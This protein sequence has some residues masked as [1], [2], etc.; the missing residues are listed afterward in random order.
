MGWDGKQRKYAMAAVLLL[1]AMAAIYFY[2]HRNVGG[3]NLPPAAPLVRVEKMVMRDMKKRVVLS[4]ETVARAS[5]DISPK[6]AGRIASVEVEL[7]DVV[8]AGE[9]LIRQDVRDVSVSILQNHAQRAEASAEA[10]AARATFGADTAKARTNFETAKATYERYQTLYEAGAVALQERDEKYRAMT[11][12]GAVLAALEDQDLGGVSATVAAKE[13][14][15]AKAAYMVE[16]LELEREDLAIKS[17]VAGIVSYRK[18][19][20][21]EWATAGETLL[22]V[23]DTGRLYLD[24]LVAE[25]DVSVLR[26][27]METDVSLESIGKTVKGIVSFVAPAP[28]SG[29]RAYRVRLVLAETGEAIRAGLFGRAAVEGV[30]R[31][32]TMYVPKEAVSNENGKLYVY[33]ISADGVA[34]KRAVKTGLSNDEDVEILSGIAAGETVAVTNAA[35]LSDGIRVQID[36]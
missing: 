12:A 7:G 35:R 18:A 32:R 23:V 1:L 19:E 34:E 22:T 16:A 8:A 17:P 4:G 25:Q 3:G 30:Q 24:C 36:G 2:T 6:Y 33:V 28:E 13:A 26:E 15:A 14:A 29:S 5:V 20:A 27:G 10:V 11:E 31:V 21:G 9:V